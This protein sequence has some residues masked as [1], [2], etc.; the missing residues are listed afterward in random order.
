MF[1][2]VLSSI[3]FDFFCELLSRLALHKQLSD[4]LAFLLLGG[5]FSD[6]TSDDV[7]TPIYRLISIT[8]VPAIRTQQELWMNSLD[9]MFL[10]FNPGK[11]GEMSFLL[12]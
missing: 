4:A 12:R 1:T 9:K 11:F 3:F 6:S 5:I 10:L 8:G 7:R 2:S